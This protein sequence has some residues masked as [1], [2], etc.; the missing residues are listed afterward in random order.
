M[1][2]Q[3]TSDKVVIAAAHD[4]DDVV[5]ATAGASLAVEKPLFGLVVAAY[6]DGVDQGGQQP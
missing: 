3:T 2:Q 6:D 4:G 1:V 5:V